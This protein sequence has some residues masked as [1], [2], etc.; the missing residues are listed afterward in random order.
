MYHAFCLLLVQ[1]HSWQSPLAIPRRFDSVSQIP[2][3]LRAPYQAPELCNFV[4]FEENT[5]IS[6][7][8]AILR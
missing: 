1:F 6:F 5:L 4:N 8:S 7:W 2:S 3:A